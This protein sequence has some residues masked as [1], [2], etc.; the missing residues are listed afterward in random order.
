MDIKDIP[1]VVSGKHRRLHSVGFDVDDDAASEVSG[2]SDEND[3]AAEEGN[4]EE[5]GVESEEAKR[6][7]RVSSEPSL[8]RTESGNINIRDMLDRWNEP[9]NNEAKVSQ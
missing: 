1:K 5:K 2:S 4:H 7:K 9:V 3:D 6:F 8:F